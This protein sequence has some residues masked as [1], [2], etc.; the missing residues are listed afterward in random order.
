[1]RIDSFIRQAF[2]RDPAV[3]YTVRS[4]KAEGL[5]LRVTFESAA[6]NKLD[7][8]IY[9]A[10]EAPTTCASTDYLDILFPSRGREDLDDETRRD[11]EGVLD[12]L[13][14]LDLRPAYGDWQETLG[15]EADARFICGPSVEIKLT[16]RCNQQCIFCKSSS[17][18]ENYATASQ[19]PDLMERLARRADFITFSGGE[20][21]LDPL[22]ERHIGEA[23]R[24]GFK[25]IEV[26]TN[27]MLMQD[28][29]YVRRL[30]A[31]GMTNV[32]VSLHSHLPDVSDVITSLAGSFG[33]TL[34][35]IE[36]LL[37]EHVHVA[38]CHV[39]CSLNHRHYPD[40]VRFVLDRFPGSSMT[41]VTTLAIPTHRVRHQPDLMPR[42]TDL[43]PP[44]IEGLLLCRPP[45]EPDMRDTLFDMIEHTAGAVG[46]MR[47]PMRRLLSAGKKTLGVRPLQARVIAHCG[48]PLCF[49]KGHE[50]YH[51]D[52]RSTGSLRAESD[53]Y[54]PESCRPCRWLDRCSGIWRIYA[55]RYG[56]EEIRPA[57][58]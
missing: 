42:L 53:L 39:L 51:D 41:I 36:T 15:P 22:L 54:R 57:V 46:M 2:S 1:M 16:R 27:G 13:K 29:A 9:P 7:L 17:R 8:K 35:G 50:E 3:P 56:E 52:L 33:E 47:R 12:A 10:G 31:A 48:L 18:L 55:S 26:Q 44:L 19:M 58:R 24:A 30:R 43:A 32:L 4:V 34:G 49:L 21:C 5:S 20:T 45:R 38:L 37:E 6:G 25:G 28:R 14:K 40:F 23:R 11:L